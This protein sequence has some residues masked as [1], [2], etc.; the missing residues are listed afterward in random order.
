MAMKR[1]DVEYRLSELIDGELPDDQADALR[2]ELGRDAD[3]AAEHR[4]YESLETALGEL[5][6]EM[7]EVDWDLQRETIRGALERE[8]LLGPARRA[9]PARLIRWSAAAAAIVLAVL[10]GQWLLTG[11]APEPHM[12]VA[13]QAPA[14]A[15]GPAMAR[16]LDPSWPPAARAELEV[17]YVQTEP[18]TPP[19]A[20]RA[21]AAAGRP[22]TIV[23]AA[24]GLS[25]PREAAEL[26]DLDEI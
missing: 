8:A 12:Q 18:A 13:W 5:G 1:D 16:V 9:W 19:A 22:G 11:P 21:A 10:A 3:L 26:W 17:A 24:G 2:R 7:P 23:V 4:R 15:A 25:P 14:A 20:P 6:R